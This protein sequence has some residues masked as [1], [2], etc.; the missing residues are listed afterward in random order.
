MT[1][2]TA[3]RPLPALVFLLAL[4]LLAALVWWRVLNRH[5]SAAAP[6]PTTCP[7]SSAPGKKL[8]EPAAVTLTVV[9]STSRQGIA[10][11]TRSVLLKDG[12]RIPNKAVNDAPS[13]GGNGKAIAGVAEIRYGPAGTDGAQLVAYYVPGAKL[14]QR[15]GVTDATVVVALGATF[16]AVRS[17]ADVTA[18][19]R[20]AGVTL[21]PTTGA[22]VTSAS[23]GPC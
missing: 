22:P 1:R 13:F 21:V 11:A 15:A 19:L 16:K 9:N 20:A 4:C 2:P 5:P 3:R 8:P 18:A 23:P 17:P 6:K 7:S 10:A 14:V 12:F